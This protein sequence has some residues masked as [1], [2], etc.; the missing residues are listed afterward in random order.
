[1]RLADFELVLSIAEQEAKTL[2][3][4]AI[5]KPYCSNGRD[6]R[7]ISFI[8]NDSRGNYYS[9][10]YTGA[11]NDADSLEWAVK[12]TIQKMRVEC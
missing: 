3:F 2:P 4:K 12:E 8:V 7:G 11:Y 9:T 1:M 5:V 10:W 6:A